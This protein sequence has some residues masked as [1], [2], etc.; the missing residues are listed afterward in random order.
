MV[1]GDVI[2]IAVSIGLAI[3]ATLAAVAVFRREAAM[4]PEVMREEPPRKLHTEKLSKLPPEAPAPHPVKERLASSFE[5]S[6]IN[7][8]PKAPAPNPVKERLVSSF[9]SSVINTPPKAPA[10]NP[11]KEKPVSS[12]SNYPVINASPNRWKTASEIKTPD[13][14]ALASPGLNSKNCNSQ[15]RVE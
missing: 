10:P 13:T 2:R 14:V 8:P 6:V 1:S 7:T 4:L 15:S 12:F 3:A 9:D 11:V 5:S